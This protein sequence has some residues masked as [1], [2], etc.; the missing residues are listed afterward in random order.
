[1]EEEIQKLDEITLL[2]TVVEETFKSAKSKTLKPCK[3]K[4]M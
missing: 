4:R 1:V 3:E 2:L